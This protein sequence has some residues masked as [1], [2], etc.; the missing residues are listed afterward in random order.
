MNLPPSVRV[1][2][3]SAFKSYQGGMSSSASVLTPAAHSGVPKLVKCTPNSGLTYAVKPGQVGRNPLNNGSGTQQPLHSLIRK[4]VTEE[5]DGSDLQMHPL[6]FQTPEDGHFPY[7]PLN[8]ATTSSSFNFF[9]GSSPLL[10]LTLFHHQHPSSHP[11]NFHDKSPNLKESTSSFGVDFHPLLKKPDDIM[12]GAQS[13]PLSS[14]NQES[15]EDR[16]A[17]L[18]RTTLISHVNNSS[19]AASVIPISPTEKINELDLDIHLSCSARRQKALGI[20]DVNHCN[21]DNTVVDPLKFSRLGSEKAKDSLAQCSQYLPAACT[22]DRTSSKLAYVHA[23][24]VSGDGGNQKNVDNV[25]DQSPPEIVMEQEELSDSE[26]EIGENVE[27]E[28]EEMAD[29]EAEDGS[30]SEP[31]TEIQNEVLSPII[32]FLLELGQDDAT[33]PSLQ[34]NLSIYAF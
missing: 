3:Q 26:D 13:A 25:G 34:C 28:C 33:N 8:S 11:V 14:A 1:M 7:Y 20:R 15:S 5:K 18:R 27:F 31:T 24:N 2:S 19:S 10:N 6:L 30:D 32:P 22:P 17:Q 16:C 4:Q 9:Q 12:V 23:S 29:S 21:M